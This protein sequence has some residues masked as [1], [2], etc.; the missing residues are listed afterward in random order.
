MYGNAVKV[1]DKLTF[2][3]V[4]NMNDLINEDIDTKIKQT[5]QKIIDGEFDKKDAQSD[6]KD[7]PMEV[8]EQSSGAIALGPSDAIALGPAPEPFK[9]RDHIG[10][11][12]TSDPMDYAM[13]TTAEQEAQEREHM[14]EEDSLD[15]PMNSIA[16]PKK[17]HFY[18]SVEDEYHVEYGSTGAAPAIQ[19]LEEKHQEELRKDQE[20]LDEIDRNT[21]QYLQQGEWV[22]T[23]YS[24][25]I[26]SGGAGGGHYSAY[27]KSYEDKTWYHFNDSTVSEIKVSQIETMYG[28]GHSSKNAY[29][30]IYKKYH[31]AQ[32]ESE[33]SVTV[34]DADI[35]NYVQDEVKIDNDKFDQEERD[36]LELEALRKEQAAHITLRVY[37]KIHPTDDRTSDIYSNQVSLKDPKVKI[38][39]KKF[40][41]KNYQTLYEAKLNAYQLYDLESKGVRLEDTQ[42][43]LYAVGF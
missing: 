42:L 1:N 6:D 2:P 28:D 36:R 20:I 35:P 23:L 13:S 43:R 39:E 3:Y 19:T 15:D 38:D 32:T 12:K 22:Y 8:D 17:V 9:D 24:V 18:G 37:C 4:L 33:F 40:D 14:G 26:H 29:L 10:V 30:V 41:F 16:G 5:E 25:L 11:I 21:Q 27:I 31:D 34:T 7:Q